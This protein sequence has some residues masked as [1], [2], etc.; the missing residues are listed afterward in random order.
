MEYQNIYLAYETGNVVLKA[1]K[2]DKSIVYLEASNEGL[3]QQ[4]EIVLKS[5]LENSKDYFMSHGVLSWDHQHK[6]AKDPQY[7]IGEPLDVKFTDDNKTLVKGRLYPEVELAKSVMKMLNSNSTRLGA[8]VGGSN[9]VKSSVY[10]DT[11]SKVVPVI[12]D[13]NWDEVAITHKPVN[14]ETL[15]KCTYSKMK[16]FKK[17]F[18]FENDLNKNVDNSLHK[19]EKLTD[20]DY[21]ISDLLKSKI[22]NKYFWKDLLGNVMS[23]SIDNYNDLDK[24]LK[25]CGITGKYDSV[26]VAGIIE[27]IIS[28]KK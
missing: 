21:L 19:G 27:N 22:T 1:D 28:N 6:I 14:D 8:S 18:I 25:N 7:I 11:A 4:D 23:K 26:A 15:G 10:S 2:D 9:V 24:Y 20:N 5:A 3:D 17:S 16:D 12:S 13:F